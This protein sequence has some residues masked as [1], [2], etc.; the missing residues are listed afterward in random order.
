MSGHRQKVFPGRGGAQSLLTA[1]ELPVI[2]ALGTKNGKFMFADFF[3][4]LLNCKHQV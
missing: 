2:R 4:I 1:K 3:E